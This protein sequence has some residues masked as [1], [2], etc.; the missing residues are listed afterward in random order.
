EA[1]LM[2]P[3]Y[4]APLAL[5][6]AGLTL[7]DLTLIDMH[8]AFAALVLTNLDC[9]ASEDFAREKLNRTAALGDVDPARFN[10]L[11][12]SIAY[13]RP[14]AA[15]GARMVTQSLRELKR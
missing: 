6:R 15:T 11:G 12:G 13:G 8:G 4:A 5:A 10:V 1:L 3:S 2:G 14:Y 7:S 9:F